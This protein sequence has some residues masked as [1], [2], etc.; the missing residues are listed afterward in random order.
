M[1][2]AFERWFG[3]SVVL[4]QDGE[5][6]VMYHGT[7]DRDI[8]QFDRLWSLKMR[9]PSIDNLGIWISDNPSSHGGAGM[10]GNAIYPVFV[11]A[12]RTKYFESFDELVR[13]MHEAATPGLAFDKSRPLG[14]GDVGP[15]RAT[16]QAQGYDSVGITRTAVLEAIQGLS[17]A[18]QAARNAKDEEWNVPKEQREPY[19]MK[20]KRLEASVE[21]I[22]TDLL[23]QGID[24]SRPSVEFD[25]QNC[26]IVFEPTQIKSAI[27]ALNF[28][29]ENPYI[30]DRS[31]AQVEADIHAYC[32]ECQQKRTRAEQPPHA[33][34]STPVPSAQ[35]LQWFGNSAAV[36]ASGQPL[37]LFHGSLPGHDIY[38][39]SLPHISSTT[40]LN[41]DLQQAER[42]TLHPTLEAGE[43][44]ALYP[45]YA[46]V[47][48]PYVVYAAPGSDEWNAFS[49]IR[50]RVPELKEQGFDSAMLYNAQAQA[51]EQIECF[52][53][54][55]TKSA[56]SAVSYARGNPYLS[57]RD[58]HEICEDISAYC[59][60]AA[61]RMAQDSVASGLHGH[62]ARDQALARWME[63]SVAVDASGLPLVLYHGTTADLDH[64]ELA[65]NGAHG[66]AYSTPAIFATDNPAIASDYA[67]SNFDREIGSAMR[68]LQRIKNTAPSGFGDDYESAY[69]AVSDAF[70]KVSAEGRATTGGGGNVLPLHM[71]LCKPLRIDAR[72]AV[73][74]D[75][76]PQA[77]KD[78]VA[79]GCDGLIVMNV[80]DPAS[81]KSLM[82]SNVYVAL[83]PESVKSA[84][85]AISFDSSTP[86]LSDRS[87]AQLVAEVRSF[88]DQTKLARKLAV[89]QRV[90]EA[91]RPISL[92][93]AHGMV[94]GCTDKPGGIDPTMLYA[95]GPSD[96]RTLVLA[97]IPLELVR[98]NEAEDRYDGTVDMARAQRYAAMDGTPPPVILK[99]STREGDLLVLDGGHRVTS[100]R[101]RGDSHILALCDVWQPK[102][103]LEKEHDKAVISSSDCLSR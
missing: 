76:M 59:D 14:L 44:G 36:D 33:P 91:G 60:N 65:F 78:A 18:I 92:E 5:P 17:E 94:R 38:D 3:N 16:L 73:F 34:P 32:T 101:L 84:I 9:Q 21:A 85:S 56:V 43:Q 47:Q 87:E 24:P 41:T 79:Q 83:N 99:Q 70:A 95:T 82:P 52:Y 102:F 100:S 40:R 19:T 20:R 77:M 31:L 23:A 12:E 22:R 10:Y 26:L 27:G 72:G 86:F 68:M 98:R 80:V 97:R 37:M 50:S 93:E 28:D 8:D 51:Y 96:G 69:A 7:Y 6:L 57:D 42:A 89:A 1:S 48:A 64:F 67:A 30:A 15:L 71:R 103:L 11:R 63:G 13:A 53:P 45:V 66:T 49:D 61:R 25:R 62:S 81:D 4:N 55:Q 90:I 29:L 35:F 75:L 39:F 74:T 54:D 46:S 2:S 58:E 88:C